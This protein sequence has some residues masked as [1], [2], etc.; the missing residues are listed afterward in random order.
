MVVFISLVPLS[1]SRAAKS[2]DQT[3]FVHWN[4]YNQYPEG[5]QYTSPGGAQ[6]PG[7]QYSYQP[8]N[9]PHGQVMTSVVK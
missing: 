6:Y 5:N 2:N 4:Q 8:L 7:N 9:N 1:N 3:T